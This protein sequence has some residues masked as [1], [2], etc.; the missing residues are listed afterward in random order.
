MYL[1]DMVYANAVAIPFIKIAQRFLPHDTCYDFIIK[2]MT[3]IFSMLPGLHKKPEEKKPERKGKKIALVGKAAE[4]HRL[5]EEASLKEEGE[6]KLK[7]TYIIEML[8]KL[9]ALKHEELNDT[10]RTVC[11]V[12]NKKH[13]DDHKRYDRG[14]VQL[15]N[16]WGNG[17]ALCDSYIEGER[18]KVR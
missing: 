9:Q 1:N 17:K 18:E 6:R 12:A 7:R 10:M 16:F 4:E 2:F 8:K 15:M 5:K 14:I 11:L 3:M 13:F